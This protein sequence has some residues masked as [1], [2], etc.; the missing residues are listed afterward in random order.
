M[1]ARTSLFTAIGPPRGYPVVR[2]PALRRRAITYPEVVTPRPSRALG[3]LGAV[4]A[5]VLATIGTFAIYGWIEPSIS[6][7]FFP[8]V[9]VPAMYGVR[10]GFSGH[11]AV[12]DR[13]RVLLRG[14]AAFAHHPRR[15]SRSARRLF[16]RRRRDGMAQLAACPRRRG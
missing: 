14:A 1:S 9:L 11:R 5:V 4:A 7:L 15:R 6:L 13:P 8:A 3:H 16:G 10:S 12:H 2:I